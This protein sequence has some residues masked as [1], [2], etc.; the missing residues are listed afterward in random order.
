MTEVRVMTNGV[1]LEFPKSDY[2]EED[3]ARFRREAWEWAEKD[4][5]KIFPDLQPVRLRNL[6][7]HVQKYGV[8]F[9]FYADPD[10]HSK[11]VY[12][13]LWEYDNK[14]LIRRLVNLKELEEE[15][16]DLVAYYLLNGVYAYLHEVKPSICQKV[17]KE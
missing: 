1:L 11:A 4:H 8:H 14:V 9:S 6:D 7:K 10:D 12:R 3:M 16:P 15:H 17:F 2:T 5:K 13:V